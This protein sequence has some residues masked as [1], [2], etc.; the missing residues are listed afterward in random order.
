MVEK[1]IVAEQAVVTTTDLDAISDEE[2]ADLLT[3]KL[4]QM[5]LT[6]W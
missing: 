1:A 6:S 3:A 2:A 5:G 4:A